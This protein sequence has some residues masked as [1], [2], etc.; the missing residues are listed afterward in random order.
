MQLAMGVDFSED[1]SLRDGLFDHMKAAVQRLNDGLRIRNPL[2]EQIHRD[3][4]GLFGVVREA[5]DAA[6]PELEVPDE[7]VG[8][9]VM[10]F[11]ASL[12]RLKRLRRHVRAVVVCTSGI[13]SSK[14]L[15]IRLQK[16]SPQVEI[17][18][19]ASWYE[20]S[21]I[22]EDNYDFI[23]STIDLPLEPSQYMKV[24]PCSRRRK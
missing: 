13:G 21:R 22:P 23:I 5:A 9:L 24:S 10:H 2:L 14:M 1:R 4:S 3:Y 17:V 8:F 19:R 20:A 6:L 18:D 7:E 11:G 16:E 12:E 15:Q